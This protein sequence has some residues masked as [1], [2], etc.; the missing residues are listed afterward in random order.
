[1]WNPKKPGLCE[2]ITGPGLEEA[3]E[4]SFVPSAISVP[5]KPMFRC[6]NRCSEKAISFWQF[7]SVVIEEVRNPTRPTCPS[8]AT[9]KL[10]WQKGDAPLTKWQWYAVVEKKA[11]RGR[12]WRMLV[13]DQNIQGMWEYFS[14]ERGCRKR[15]AGRDTRPKATRIA[16]QGILGTIEVL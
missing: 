11:H 6:D 13:K 12:L 2:R 4:I 10:C 3:E 16:S 1:M 15:E 9:T 5:P 14:L 8:N 7:A